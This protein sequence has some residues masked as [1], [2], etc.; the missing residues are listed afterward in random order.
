M[1][2]QGC[3]TGITMG[4]V[5]PEETLLGAYIEN[6]LFPEEKNRVESHLVECRMCREVIARAIKTLAALSESPDSH[7]ES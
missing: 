6:N 1:A 4:G 5:C 3:L 2:W 7:L